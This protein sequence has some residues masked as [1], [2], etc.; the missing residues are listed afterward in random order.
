MSEREWHDALVHLHAKAGCPSTRQIAAQAGC[1]HTAVADALRGQ[2][3]PRLETL[4]V[5][6]EALGG[7]F[8]EFP[9]PPSPMRAKVSKYENLQRQQLHELQLIRALLEQIVSAQGK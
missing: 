4:K 6:V 5:I 8:A 7:D 1:A 2:T 3:N 9:L